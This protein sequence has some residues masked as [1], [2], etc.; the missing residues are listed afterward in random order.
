M[1][2]EMNITLEGVKLEIR[3]MERP[4]L[5]GIYAK[6]ILGFDFYTAKYKDCEFILLDPQKE[7]CCGYRM[8]QYSMLSKWIGEAL[9]KPVAY[10][11]DYRIYHEENWMPNNR[12]VYFIFS[13]EYV[14]LPFLFEEQSNCMRHNDN[15]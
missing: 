9:R 12:G 13:D 11:F 15:N 4:E 10:F 1:E 3:K 14:F 7:E 6:E 5:K 8:K 2:K